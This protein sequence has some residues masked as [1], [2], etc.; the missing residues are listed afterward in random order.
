MVI[1]K[2]SSLWASEV[3]KVINYWKIEFAKVTEATQHK[4]ERFCQ[5]TIFLCKCSIYYS[6]DMS[7]IP[8]A[9]KDLLTNYGDILN[10]STRRKA[11]AG[12]I[13]LRSKNQLDA[14][15]TIK[16]LMGLMNI[17]DK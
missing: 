15:T 16:Y 17:Q 2:D 1:K 4:N 6:G 14:A 3:L 8:N 9:L 5:F 11:A 12:L 7:F 13:I 10:P